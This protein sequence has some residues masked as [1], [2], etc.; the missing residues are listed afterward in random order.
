MTHLRVLPAVALGAALF[1]GTARADDAVAEDR[2]LER[3]EIG[4]EAEKVISVLRWRAGQ[5]ITVE[6]VDEWI[7]KL[8]N[9][10]FR[11]REKAMRALLKAGLFA[12]DHLHKALKDPDL[13]RKARAQA[14]LKQIEM[15]SARLGPSVT[16]AAMRRLLNLH[17]PEALAA[18]LLYLPYVSSEEERTELW[19]GLADLAVKNGKADPGLRKYLNA[20]PQQQALAACF[21]GRWGDDRDKAAVRKLLESQDAEVR[22]RAAQ[23]LLAGRDVSGVPALI[24]LLEHK[25]ADLAAQAEELLHWLAGKEGPAAKARPDSRAWEKWW[26]EKKPAWE[27]R[28]A[29]ESRPGLFLAVVQTQFDGAGKIVLLGC[30][31]QPRW[32]LAGLQNPRDVQWLENGRL[33]VGESRQATERSRAG[34][35]LWK[36]DQ[37]PADNLLSCQ[38]LTNG[39]LVL[40]G[41]SK[42]VELSPAKNDAY[43]SFV[44]VARRGP[45]L[46]TIDGRIAFV[47]LSGSVLEMETGPYRLIEQKA[48]VAVTKND[49]PR[50]QPLP[51]GRYFISGFKSG[52]LLE[53][54]GTGKTVWERTVAGAEIAVQLP[55]GTILAGG[56]N[57]SQS[58]LREL[59]RHGRA[60]WEGEIEGRLIAL[61][62]CMQRVR[63]GFEPISRGE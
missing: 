8:G 56:S 63:L 35:L 22:L 34:A 52:R 53:I 5:G 6:Q 60:T 11:E 24:A 30:D 44:R 2:I 3:A 29:A 48:S 50:V 19:F 51:Q 37:D 33:L 39:N 27:W 40:F 23:G 58:R 21:L 16:W 54:D 17:H 1:S 18:L 20:A 61:C 14:V 13:E 55:G 32:V 47:D 38:R 10:Q 31:L 57:R 25:N 46:V 12:A 42:V 43:S 62:P 49:R 26:R 7:D 9:S 4:L 45:G 41:D 36:R 15:K 59:D 28:Q